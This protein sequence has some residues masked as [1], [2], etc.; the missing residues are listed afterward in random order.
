MTLLEK[1]VFESHFLLSTHSEHAGATQVSFSAPLPVYVDNF[2]N[3]PVGVVVPSGFYDRGK[4]AWLHADNGRV[5]KILSVNAGMADL[6]IS[7]SNTAATSAQLTALGVSDSERTQLASL[8]SVGK[9]LWRM[10]T[11][12]FTSYDYNEPM[13]PSGPPASARLPDGGNPIPPV[14]ED[15]PACESGSII[16]CQNQT[17]G[18][19]LAV[20][21]TPFTLNYRSDRALDYTAA[22]SVDIPLVGA[23]VPPEAKSVE[24][25]IVAAGMPRLIQRFPVQANSSYRFIWNGR[26]PFGRRLSSTTATIS[27]ANVYDGVYYTSRDDFQ[28]AWANTAANAAI[29]VP[30]RGEVLVNRQHRVKI[31]RGT[32]GF[33]GGWTLDAHHT[34]DVQSRVLRYGDGRQRNTGSSAS[35]ANTGNNEVTR[36]AGTGVHGFG[37]YSVPATESQ[38]DILWHLTV[39]PDGSVFVADYWAQRVVKIDPQ[40][41]VT[42]VA[43]TGVPGYN[44]DNRLATTAHLYHPR[45]VAAA[46]DGGFYI[47][48]GANHRIRY[49]NAQGI[50][51]TVAG[52]GLQGFGGDGGPA[53]AAQLHWPSDVELAPDGTVYVLDTDNHRVRKIS[54]GGLITTVA[55][56]GVQGYGGDGGPAIQASLNLPWGMDL[57]SDG[58]IYIADTFNFRVR[59]VTTDGFIRTVAGNGT[60]GTTGDNA[61]ATSATLDYPKDVV[62]RTNGSFLI[63]PWFAAN[64]RQIDTRGIITTVKP[65]TGGTRTDGADPALLGPTGLALGHDGSVYVADTDH[66]RVI[67]LD[68]LLSGFDGTAFTVAE[69]DGSVLYEFSANGLHQRTL[70]ALTRQPLYTFTYAQGLPTRI[71]DGDGNVTQIDYDLAGTPLALTAPD[72]QRTE[73]TVDANGFLATTRNPAGETQRFAYTEGSLLTAM[74]DPRGHTSTF[75]YDNDGRLL[76]DTNAAGGGWQLARTNTATGYHVTMTSAENRATNYAIEHF[77]DG[78]QRRTDTAPDT[79]RTITTEQ[80]DGL[81]TVRTADGTVRE[82][83]TQPDP[84]F[85]SLAAYPGTDKVALPSG[86]QML[87]TQSRAVTFPGGTPASLRLTDTVT[88]NGRTGTTVFDQPTRTLTTTSPQGRTTSSVLDTQG[89]VTQ[90]TLPGIEPV[91]RS[92]DLRGRLNLTSQSSGATQRTTQYSYNPQGYLDTVTDAIN[93]NT[94]FEYDLAGRVTKQTLPDNRIIQFAYD[95]QGNLTALVPPGRDAHAFRYNAVDLEDEYT[96]PDL[97]TGRT[98][99]QYMYNLDK[100]LELITRP[101]GQT[102]DLEYDNAGRLSRRVVPNGVYQ[103]AYHATT[104]QLSTLTAPSGQTLNYTYDGFLPISETWN[105]AI[106]GTVSRTYDN[107]F[108]LTGLNVNGQSINFAY[109]ND[110]LL[111]N[112]GSLTLARNIQNGLLTGTSLGFVTTSTNYSP[113]GEM[114]QDTARLSGIVQYDVTYTRDKLGRITEKLET[115]QGQTKRY[116]YTY[117]LAGRLHQVHHDG[118]LV[119]QYTYDSNGNRIG[120]FTPSGNITAAYDTQDRLTNYNSATFTYTTNGELLTKT[121]NSATTHYDYDVLGNLR[122]VRLPNGTVIDYFIDGQDRRIGKK[123]NGA[124]VQGFLYQ[125]QLKPIAEL[126]AT[127]NVI[128]HFVYASKAHAP[129]YMIKNNETFR[130]ITDHLGSVRL[131]INTSTGQLAQRIDYDEFGN[132]ITDTNPGFQPFGFAGGLYD[133]HTGLVRFGARDYDARIG[134]WTVKDPIR[135]AGGDANLFGYAWNNPL[136]IVDPSGEIGLIGGAAVVASGAA[137]AVA[138]YNG[139]VALTNLRD[140]ANAPYE[141]LATQVTQSDP[142][143]GDK[144]QQLKDLVGAAGDAVNSGKEY[145]GVV[146]QVGQL[147]KLFQMKRTVE[148]ACPK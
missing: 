52:T 127:G 38:L 146:K 128:A 12:H 26:D 19:R 115:V 86:K 31:G 68:T 94:R 101:D 136:N 28:N 70:H 90:T 129:D 53:T 134:R 29:T 55:G 85:G 78:G 104:G 110:G 66:A 49:V 91:N 22:F 43:G 97:V 77:N 122:Q 32:H 144:Q 113:F 51:S 118:V 112:A 6:D 67:K 120:G 35:A 64:L 88:T 5:V 124:L 105:G 141:N 11:R 138:A 145:T 73:F 117:D 121:E 54:P 65:R 46:P 4:A 100:Q 111:I 75:Q 125:N 37:P 62:V 48:D 79:T 72:G 126:D 143:I 103:F 9:S 135:F 133:Q 36:F 41:M 148:G 71:T 34:Y 93:R 40:G 56:N 60:N 16:E 8:Y 87:T 42:V 147:D 27:V 3:F 2:L 81:T 89:R 114:S 21:G 106:N 7:G 10:P 84:R 80:T 116:S 44:G 83:N 17:L 18:E 76:R 45:S 131:V 108:W 132:V 96:P 139:H 123:I 30:A 95:S 130:I 47:A 74:T 15:E 102:I 92:Y 59:L 140:K 107:N 25:H 119:S 57:A 20:T 13:G 61:L 137:L 50:I 98:I 33:L 23:A 58:S 99:T 82:S 39:G 14:P 24:V 109:D 1:N 69:T 142:A 63:S